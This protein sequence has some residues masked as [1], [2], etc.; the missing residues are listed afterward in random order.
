[1][2]GL[3]R[4]WLAAALIGLAGLSTS[5]A[6]RRPDQNTQGSLTVTFKVESSVGVVFDPAG[7][8]HIIAANSLD[9]ADNVSRIEYVQ[10]SPAKNHEQKQSH[11]IKKDRS[12]AKPDR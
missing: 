5:M 11:H 10:L 2:E 4:V 7:E 6:K 12:P 9:P 8:Q 1:M 3:K